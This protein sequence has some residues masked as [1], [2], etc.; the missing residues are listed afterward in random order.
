MLT[1]SEDNVSRNSITDQIRRVS[2]SL[3]EGTASLLREAILPG[4][5]ESE[6][7][8]PRPQPAETVN[9]SD[10]DRL[11]DIDGPH[12]L[13]PIKVRSSCGRCRKPFY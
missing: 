7:L 1:A 8:V 3:Y 13:L 6:P 4:P 5:V 9:P 10:T 2:E 11:I 12:E